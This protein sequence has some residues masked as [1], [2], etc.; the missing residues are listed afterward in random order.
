MS[1]VT[2]KA[3]KELLE[4]ELEPINT[5]L[6]VIEEIVSDHTTKLE[7]IEEIVSGHTAI[8]ESHAAILE[9]HTTVLDGIAKDVKILKGEKTITAS[10]LDNL[11]DWGKKVGKRLDIKLEV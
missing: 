11:E 5:K 9:S 2:L 8:L 10:R 4:V 3:I 7:A 6:A 1:E